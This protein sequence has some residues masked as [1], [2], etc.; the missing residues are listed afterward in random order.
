MSAKP[1][2]RRSLLY[3]GVQSARHQVLY[4]SCCLEPSSFSPCWFGVDF[5]RN[6]PSTDP[7]V[8]SLLSLRSH[9]TGVLSLCIPAKPRLWLLRSGTDI[10]GVCRFNHILERNLSDQ[11][12]GSNF[13]HSWRVTVHFW[14]PKLFEIW[15]RPET[16]KGVY[17]RFSSSSPLGFRLSA[18]E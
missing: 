1:S 18:V 8:R 9:S 12:S 17:G 13:L 11:A 4:P 3:R 14:G 10:T 5:H 7:S 16:L 6:R 2:A 15:R